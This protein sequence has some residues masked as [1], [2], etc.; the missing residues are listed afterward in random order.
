M[1]VNTIDR[2]IKRG[3]A[4]FA[5]VAIGFLAVGATAASAD[6]GQSPDSVVQLGFDWN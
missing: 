1:R 2:W 4:V 6:P 5:A 3:A